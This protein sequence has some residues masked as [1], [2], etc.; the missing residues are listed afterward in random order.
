[1]KDEDFKFVEADYA[2]LSAQASGRYHAWDANRAHSCGDHPNEEEAFEQGYLQAFA[3]HRDQLAKLA[4]W[5]EEMC[6]IPYPEQI[7]TTPEKFLKHVI[8]V[9]RTF[10]RAYAAKAE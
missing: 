9:Q 5:A 7:Y 6:G 10:L 3:H 4:L 2:E 1:M 8:E